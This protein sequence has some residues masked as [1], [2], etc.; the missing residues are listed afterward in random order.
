[1]RSRIEGNNLYLPGQLPRDEYQKVAKAI[2]AAGGKWNRK[3]GCHVFPHDVRETLNIGE[4]SVE[5]VNVQQTF[6]SFNT[7]DEIASQMCQWADLTAGDKLL[8]PSA[9]TGRLIHAALSSGILQSDIVAVEVDPKKASALKCRAICADFLSCNGELGKFDR[10]LMNPPFSRGQDVAH[11]MHALNFLEEGG[12]LVAIC[13]ASQAAEK[14][15]RP[16]S[17]LWREIEAGAFKESGTG[18]KTVML[19]IDTAPVKG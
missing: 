9:G 13:S 17:S 5:V 6:Q 16:L 14:A 2:E 8:E 18:V 1:M 19:M 10:I 4:D 15:L 12:R 11:I 7:P 3:A